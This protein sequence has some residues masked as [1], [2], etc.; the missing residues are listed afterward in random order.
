MQRQNCSE[1]RTIA[2]GPC[3]PGE[4]KEADTP[5]LQSSIILI[6]IPPYMSSYKQRKP[7][8]GRKVNTLSNEAF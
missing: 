8:P 5:Q 1:P 6:H 7:I 2:I 4:R 3:S